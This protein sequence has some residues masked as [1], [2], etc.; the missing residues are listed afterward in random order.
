L[1]TQPGEIDQRRLPTPGHAN[2][3]EVMA[4]TMPVQTREDN[5]ET[6]AVER[7]DGPTSPAK[8]GRFTTIAA[9]ACLGA[10]FPWLLFCCISLY[11]S[12]GPDPG[13]ISM[14]WLGVFVWLAIAIVG[15]CVLSFVG[16][17]FGLAAAF[18][19]GRKGVWG[20]VAL[21]LNALVLVV[22]LAFILFAQLGHTGTR[23]SGQVDPSG[24]GVGSR[25]RVEGG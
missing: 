1:L 3:E 4:M 25:F 19:T 22:S 6:T 14:A 5:Q 23:G 8:G 20:A 9:F 2:D 12:L 13:E 10:L 21:G 16:T 11:I 15:V 7:G 18:G 24:K 17:A